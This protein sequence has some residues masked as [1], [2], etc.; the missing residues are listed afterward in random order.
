MYG[1]FCGRSYRTISAKKLLAKLINHFTIFILSTICGSVLANPSLDG[2]MLLEGLRTFDG[3][4]K[5]GSVY[6]AVLNPILNY[7]SLN[8]V[9]SNTRVGVLIIGDSNNTFQYKNAFQN[10][11]NMSAQ[12][13]IR[14]SELNY[15]Q[16]LSHSTNVRLGVMDMRDYLNSYDV[17]KELFNSG[18]GTNRVMNA[19]T[20]VATYPY[21]GFGAIFKYSQ[22]S[23]SLDSAVFQGNPQHLN[24]IFSDGALFIE[25]LNL[26][27]ALDQKLERDFYLKIGLWGN[28]QPKSKVGFSNIGTYLM[29]QYV[30]LNKQNQNMSVF[31]QIGYSNKQDNNIPYS[32]ATGITCKGLFSYRKNDRAAFGFTSIWLRHLKTE[33]IFELTYAIYLMQDFYLNPDLQYIINPRGSLANSWG[34]VLRLTYIFAG[35]LIERR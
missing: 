20:N 11:S 14:L 12:R 4:L 34:G 15:A 24:S 27:F 8:S 10:I 18:F 35:H 33:T 1:T 32:F 3:G 29:G 6:N 19:G 9:Q 22:P 31:A 26:N 17:P 25:Q 21:S 23:Y 30:W 5:P 28:Y 13:Q 16:N 2:F 7:Q